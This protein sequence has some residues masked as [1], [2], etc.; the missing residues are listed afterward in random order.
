[1]IA[2]T[3]NRG[4]SVARQLARNLAGRLRGS[5]LWYRAI[6]NHDRVVTALVERLDAAPIGPRDSTL[7]IAATGHGNIG[8]Q[9]MLEAFLDNTSGKIT[10]VLNAVSAAT[11][12]DRHRDRVTVVALPRLIDGNPLSRTQDVVRFVRLARTS[13]HVSVVGADLM[14]GLYNPTGSISRSSC[15]RGALDLG[16][17]ARIVGFSWSADAH[18]SAIRALRE[19]GSSV[20]CMAREPLSAERLRAC[21][22]ARVESVAD[23]VFALGGEEAYEP[24]VKWSASL[25]PERRIALVNMSALI[26]AR[27]DQ[28]SDYRL[29]VSELDRRGFAI[30]MLPH[31]IRESGDDSAEISKLPVTELAPNALVIDELLSPLQI[32]GLAARADLV[33]TGR[34]H[35]AIMSIGQGAV[36]ITLGTQG[37]VEGLYRLLNIGNLEVA[38]NPGFGSQVVETIGRVD[39]QLDELR[40]RLLEDLP[41]VRALAARNFGAEANPADPVGVLDAGAIR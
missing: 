37:K 28:V 38:P 33:V 35:L 8:D 36:P 7:L 18:P 1:M 19:A 27:S 30:V 11:I 39:Q 31:V 15:L 29:I 12:P 3:R 23:T 10:V 13:G 5:G 21:G 6:W 32:R 16:A 14:D 2:E 24:F 25:G 34:M 4:R 20:Q 22:I 40:A 41:A 26:G 9:A 17:S